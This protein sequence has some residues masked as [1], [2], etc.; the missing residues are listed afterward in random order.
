LSLCGGCA[1]TEKLTV[2]EDGFIIDCP[3]LGNCAAGSTTER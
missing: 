1:W 2:M 3:Q